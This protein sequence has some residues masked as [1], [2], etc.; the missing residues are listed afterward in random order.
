MK[1]WATP[2]DIVGPAMFLASESSDYV[3]GIILP[4]DGGYLAF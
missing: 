4:V 2:E 3:N 1:R